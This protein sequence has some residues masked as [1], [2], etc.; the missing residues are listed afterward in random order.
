MDLQHL[1]D[2]AWLHAMISSQIAPHGFYK[3][4]IKRRL[5][6]VGVFMWS[7]YVQA[8]LYE[9]PESKVCVAFLTNTNPRVDGTVNFRGVN[10]FLPHRSVSILPDCKTVIYNT[11]RVI[12]EYQ[13]YFDC[14]FLP[15][16]FFK[17][18]TVG[19]LPKSRSKSAN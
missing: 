4:E 12:R 8:W 5:L 17:K 9:S 10:Y 3:K 16:Y 19:K 11:Q 14:S 7:L 1:T 18:R 13:L 2:M 15:P 6:P